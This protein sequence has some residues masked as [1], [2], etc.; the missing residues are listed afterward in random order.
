MYELNHLL[1]VGVMHL[2]EN[3]KDYMFGNTKEY[4]NRKYDPDR[5]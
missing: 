2:D 4:V 5:T 1:R 3:Q